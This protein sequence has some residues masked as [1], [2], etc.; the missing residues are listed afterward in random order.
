[1]EGKG[2]KDANRKPE[3]SQFFGAKKAILI[4]AI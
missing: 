3:L 4:L 1:M 2:W